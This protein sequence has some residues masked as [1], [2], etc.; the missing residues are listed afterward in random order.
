MVDLQ[1][2]IFIINVFVLFVIIISEP[3]SLVATVY[4][5][6]S[7]NIFPFTNSFHSFISFSDS[8]IVIPN[9]LLNIVTTNSSLK[10]VFGFFN[11][12]IID[13]LIVKSV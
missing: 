6:F 4:T 2:K 8:S 1:L 5:F 3:G 10:S 7:S 13:C 12:Y 11:V 9:V